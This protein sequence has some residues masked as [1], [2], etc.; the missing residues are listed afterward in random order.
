MARFISMATRPVIESGYRFMSK[1]YE[2]SPREGNEE[3]REREQGREGQNRG[4]WG[5]TLLTVLFLPL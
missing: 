5:H 2:L 1:V 4:E 3:R